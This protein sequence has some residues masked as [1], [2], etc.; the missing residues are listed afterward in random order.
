MVYLKIASSGIKLAY[1]FELIQVLPMAPAPSV[2][3][4]YTGANPT[5]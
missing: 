1:I 4:L 2:T 5:K 3:S